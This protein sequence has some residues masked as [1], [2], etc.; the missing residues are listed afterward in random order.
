MSLA[1]LPPALLT[2]RMRTHLP[3]APLRTPGSTKRVPTCAGGYDSFSSPC[4]ALSSRSPWPVPPIN[5]SRLAG[6]SRQPHR[7]AVWSTSEDTGCT[8]GAPE[9]ARLLSSLTQ[10]SAARVLAGALSN[11]RWRDSRASAPTIGQAWATAIPGHHRGPHAASQASWPNSCRVAG[12]PGQSCSSENPSR[13]STSV[14]SLPITRSG[15]QAS[16]SWMPR[17]RTMCMKCRG[18]RDSFLCCRRSVLSGC[19]ACLSAR[20]SSRW[21]HQFN[22]TR[23]RQGF[24][25]R[26]TARRPMKSCTLRRPY[27]RSESRA[28]SSLSLSL[29]SRVREEPTRSGDGCSKMRLHCQNEDV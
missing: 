23:R 18:W 22:D 2:C 11:P 5:G 8:C 4:A 21:L 13:V 16:Y 15:P 27:R 14:S 25:Q 1:S 12:S 17:T 3:T 26:D 19:L 7:P 6:R 29:S 9:R 20:E 24:A 28:E 10:V